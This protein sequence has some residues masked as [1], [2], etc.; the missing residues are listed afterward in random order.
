MLKEGRIYKSLVGDEDFD[1]LLAP[2]D[3]PNTYYCMDM[4]PVTEN[5]GYVEGYEFPIPVRREDIGE[6]V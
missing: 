3:Y 6:E 4:L 5:G 1:F 2:A